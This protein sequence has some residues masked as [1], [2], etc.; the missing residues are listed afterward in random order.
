MPNFTAADHAFMARAIQLAAR[1]K[2]TTQPNPAVGCVLVQGEDI[3]GEGWHEQAGK[4]HAEVNAL[5]AAGDRARNARAYVTLEPCAHHG[6]T[7]PCA[8]ALIDAGVAEVIV[9]MEDPHAKVDGRGIEALASAGVQVRSGLLQDTV[10]GSLAGFVSRM[11]RGRPFVR[12]KIAA[13]LDGGTAMKNGESQW[14]TGPEARADVQ[15]LRAMSGAIMTGIG[16]VLA[17]D[18][19]LTVREASIDMQGRQPLRVVL[20]SGLRMP[21]SAEMLALPGQTLIYCNDVSKRQP[22]EEAGAAIATVGGDGESVALNA[23]LDD[24]G[25]REINDLLVEAG[26]AL[27]GALIAQDLVDELVIYQAPHIMGSETMRMLRTPAWT[28]LADRRDLQISDLRR[29]GDDMRITAR[30]RGRS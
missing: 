2:Y 11:T 4:A 28:A 26:P 9:A 16:T 14:I 19:S 13:S 21:L 30:L 23:V 7:P 8:T 27:A 6:K 20:D 10:A 22:L 17:D 3:V 29:V 15:R 5:A 25:T 1:G 12:L 24:L 18:P